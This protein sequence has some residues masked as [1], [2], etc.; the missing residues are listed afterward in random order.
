MCVCRQEM[1]VVGRSPVKF[2]SLD[3]IFNAFISPLE[4]N[5]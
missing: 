2:V 3:K 1:M 4:F 5:V